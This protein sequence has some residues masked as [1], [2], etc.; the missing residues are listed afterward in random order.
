MANDTR[1][2]SPAAQEAIRMRVVQAVAG[3]MTYVEAAKAFGVHRN[4]P[5]RGIAPTEDG[6]CPGL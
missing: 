3:G 4:T 2:L 6:F 1:N 5:A